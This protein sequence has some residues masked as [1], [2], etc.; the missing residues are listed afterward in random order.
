MFSEE[1]IPEGMPSHSFF[2]KKL[3][4]ALGIKSL[5]AGWYARKINGIIHEYLW[6][7]HGYVPS[8]KY[9]KALKEDGYEVSYPIT[10]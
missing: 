8:Q 5:T 4:F 9:L 3:E 2:S 10:E 6:G 1:D 7:E